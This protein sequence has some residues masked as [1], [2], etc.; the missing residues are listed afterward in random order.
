MVRQR[1]L[2]T[3]FPLRP[4]RLCGRYSDSFGLRACRA[5]SIALRNPGLFGQ[6]GG[7]FDQQREDAQ[8]HSPPGQA[9]FRKPS[10]R[11]KRLVNYFWHRCP[12]FLNTGKN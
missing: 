6:E 5:R 11:G 10:L 2:R 3:F 4:L 7:T 12:F 9:F 1:T 8:R